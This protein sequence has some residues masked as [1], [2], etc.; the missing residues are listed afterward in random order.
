MEKWDLYE[1]Y[2]CD[3]EFMTNV[4]MHTEHC[5]YCAMNEPTLKETVEIMEI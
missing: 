4:N 1:C 2:Y 3:S 5:P